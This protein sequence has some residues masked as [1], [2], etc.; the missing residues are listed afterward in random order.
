[1]TT[2][3][4][5][6]GPE[7]ASLP[8]GEMIYSIA[9]AIADGQFQLDRSSI[10]AA[11]Y[12]SGQ[13]VYFGYSYDE[14][15][16]RQAHRLSMM[17]L[18]FVPTFYQF[19]DTLIEIKI[20]IQLQKQGTST[21][22]Q[23]VS[24][25][26]DG[27]DNPLTSTWRPENNVRTV[28]NTAPV[29]ARYASSYSYSAELASR[30]STKL[31]P[32]PP[33]AILEERIRIL[34]E[35]QALKRRAKQQAAEPTAATPVEPESESRL[36]QQHPLG[37][38][39]F[40]L[41]GFEAGDVNMARALV[42]RAFTV[43]AW[44]APAS[45]RD[46]DGFVGAFVDDE[47]IA[48]GWLLGVF[49]SELGFALLAAG[50]ATPTIVKAKGAYVPG[51]WHHVAGVYDGTT[52]RL[53]VNSE[54][55]NES[56]EQTGDIRYPEDA[57]FM[58]GAYHYHDGLLPCAGQ[59]DDVRLWSRALDR[60]EIKRAMSDRLQ[61][62]EP[63]LVG[64]WRVDQFRNDALP[65]LVNKRELQKRTLAFTTPKGKLFAGT[66]DVVE[67]GEVDVK[68]R[69]FTVELWA[70]RAS[71][72]RQMSA[73]YQGR[74][75][76]NQALYVGFWDTDAFTFSFKHN[77]LDTPRS[78]PETGEWHHWAC[79]YDRE[80]GSRAIYRDGIEVAN[81]RPTSSYQGSG[82]LVIGAQY[83]AADR[84]LHKFDGEITEVRLWHRAR[85]QVQIERGTRLLLS[86]KERDLVLH[87][88]F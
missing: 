48:K 85:T 10:Q 27:E 25:T 37:G 2:E 49:D 66:S 6:I 41:F 42:T 53:Y 80:R 1:M 30:L 3:A 55:R 68:D 18:G 69:S 33:P 81:D 43:E 14:D 76:K 28:V 40:D 56:T 61:G 71:R 46:R 8:L 17:E 59:I 78:Y 38:P 31:V 67:C 29:D 4:P 19:V 15:G 23:T 75:E 74:N 22:A 58:I 54:L 21:L 60:A 12:L 82:R 34:I 72:G 51:Q 7:I 11:E 32:V 77:D 26:T 86:G 50:G 35:Q 70:R 79:V 63:G 88:A 65:D 20:A 5:S 62:Q 83:D 39:I 24:S 57:L 73:V 16:Q 64:Y 47:R 9:R 87:R 13:L 84:Y 44:V 45:H 36:L 52:M